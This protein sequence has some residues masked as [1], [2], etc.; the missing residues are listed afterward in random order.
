MMVYVKYI[1][2]LIYEAT[3][4]SYIAAV[5]LFNSQPG[6]MQIIQYAKE[7][8]LQDANEKKPLDLNPSMLVVIIGD[9][10]LV[11]ILKQLKGKVGKICVFTHRANAK[12]EAD[13]VIVDT[14]LPSVV[15]QKFNCQLAP[16]HHL[17]KI[18]SDLQAIPKNKH[19]TSPLTLGI[20]VV[21][22]DINKY[23]WADQFKMFTCV[24]AASLCKLGEAELV[25][26]AFTDLW[27]SYGYEESAS[28]SESSDPEN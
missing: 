12:L 13:E 1:M 17:R 16:D 25:M 7:K 19:T 18:I 3:R 8:T 23:D 14:Y 5:V 15:M 28:E 9:K 11:Q 26:D 10:K 24:D 20:D 22:N 2:F 27:S 6:S 21:I 4:E